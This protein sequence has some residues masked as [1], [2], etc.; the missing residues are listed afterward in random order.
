M[1]F[2]N[3]FD[4]SVFEKMQYPQDNGYWII[5]IGVLI[6]GF[7]WAYFKIKWMEEDYKKG[8]YD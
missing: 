6:G 8:K 1:S 7:I 2:G 4:M 5:F 3:W